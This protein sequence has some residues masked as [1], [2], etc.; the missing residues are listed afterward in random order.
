MAIFNCYVSSPEGN[1]PA[2]FMYQLYPHI[3]A[4]KKAVKID[5]ENPTI[6]RVVFHGEITINKFG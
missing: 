5:A 2:T 3:F 1:Q 4:A 6:W